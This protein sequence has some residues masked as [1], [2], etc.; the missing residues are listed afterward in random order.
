MD[1]QNYWQKQHQKYSLF[2]WITK[3]TIF[4]QQVI[5]LF[6]KKGKLI[7][8]GA[9]QG[10]DS[11]YFAQSSFQVTST[12]FTQEALDISKNQSENLD[13]DFKNVDLTQPLPFADNSF[14]IV[15]SHLALHYFNQ[16]ITQQLFNEIHRILKTGGV[17]ATL[18]NT[19]HDPEV[20]ESTPIE[21]EF[22]LSP[23]GI[24][25]RFFSIDSLKRMVK[26]QYQIIILDEHG[27]TYKDTIKNLIRFIGKKI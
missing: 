9:G 16:T 27:E 2:D 6:P 21:P 13:I 4:A 12:D 26:N 1:P 14:D 24:E 23:V 25:K 7:D 22:W 18:V 5:S 17:F 10:Q 20:L 19:H 11:R 3:P 15:Y 8:L